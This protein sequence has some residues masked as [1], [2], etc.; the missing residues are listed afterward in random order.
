MTVPLNQQ[1]DAVEL[2]FLNQRGHVNNLSGLVAKGKRPQAELD[3][4]RMQLTPLE[5]AAA[6]MR[7]L[8]QKQTVSA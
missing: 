7:G 6:T 4:A 2:A 1:A 5:A 8:A 3:L